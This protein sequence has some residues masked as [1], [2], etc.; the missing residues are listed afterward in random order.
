MN[1]R[2]HTENADTD[3][4]RKRKEE[5]KGKER[6]DTTQFKNLQFLLTS[7]RRNILVIICSQKK[8]THFELFRT[9]RRT[10]GQTDMS[11]GTQEATPS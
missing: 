1:T 7:R 10:D 11:D 4:K 9:E 5:R 2:E 6:G 8:S 3:K